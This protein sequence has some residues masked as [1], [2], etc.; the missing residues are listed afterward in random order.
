ML[1]S[2]INGMATDERDL[3]DDMYSRA[4]LHDE[5]GAWQMLFGVETAPVYQHRG[6]AAYLMRRVILDTAISHRSGIVLTCKER[7]VGFYESFGFVDEGVSASNHGNALWHQ[8]RLML[9]ADNADET[10]SNS[11]RRAMAETTSYLDHNGT[12]TGQFR[13]LAQ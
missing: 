4:E 3:R 6:C 1:V 5:R 8:M 11:I 9:N 13:V 2:F 12:S 10:T 7:L